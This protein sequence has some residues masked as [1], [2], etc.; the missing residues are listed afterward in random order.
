MDHHGTKGFFEFGA[1]EKLLRVVGASSTY[2]VLIAS[3]VLYTS[4]GIVQDSARGQRA[5]HESFPRIG[6][7]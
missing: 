1:V 4:L 3:L 5:P 7:I 6:L 2:L